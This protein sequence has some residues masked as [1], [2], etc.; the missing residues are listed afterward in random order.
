M[1]TTDTSLRVPNRETLQQLQDALRRVKALKI[2]ETRDVTTAAPTT[3]STPNVIPIPYKKEEIT[4]PPPQPHPIAVP[5]K[6][7]PL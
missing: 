1:I 5:T 7:N 2:I 3:T 4:L 6:A